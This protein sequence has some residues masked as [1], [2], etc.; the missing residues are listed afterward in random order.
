MGGHD[1]PEETIL[2]RYAA[3]LRNFFSLYQPL[4]NT[5]RIYDNSS[6]SGPRLIARGRASTVTRVLDDEAWALI[7]REVERMRPLQSPATRARRTTVGSRSHRR[8]F[9]RMRNLAA[10]NPS[11]L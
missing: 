7:M 1:V 8:E 10:R 9:T 2:R 6:R 11:D 3:G 5:W 4:A